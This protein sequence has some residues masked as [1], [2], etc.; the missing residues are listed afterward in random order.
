MLLPLST[1]SVFAAGSEGVGR[2]ISVYPEAG[3]IS[4][5]YNDYLIRP[6]IT[7]VTLKG[8]SLG[9]D[10]LEPELNVYYRVIEEQQLDLTYK[11]PKT[12]AEIKLLGPDKLIE[13]M[14]QH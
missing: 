4:I 14:F 7:Q 13:R 12:L 6:G 10:M 1:A 2:I 8:R 3:K 11:G 5:N 9:L